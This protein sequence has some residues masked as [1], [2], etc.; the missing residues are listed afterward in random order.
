MIID[1]VVVY[2]MVDVIEV[3]LILGNVDIAVVLIF[4]PFLTKISQ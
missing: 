1:V 3:M 2:E 4:E